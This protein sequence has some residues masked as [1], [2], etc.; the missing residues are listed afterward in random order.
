MTLFYLGIA[1]LYSALLLFSG[2]GTLFV[3][4]FPKNNSLVLI[5]TYLLL[6]ISVYISNIHILIISL[7]LISISSWYIAPKITNKRNVSHHIIRLFFHIFLIGL[8]VL[9]R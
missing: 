6:L 5:L 3:A 2:I 4:D 7:I 1:Y 8:F 9:A